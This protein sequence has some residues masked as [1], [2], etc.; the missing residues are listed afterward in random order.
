MIIQNENPL[1][2]VGGFSF[3]SK[4]LYF[5]YRFMWAKK[6]HIIL[7]IGIILIAS[8]LRFYRITYHDSY[9]D[10]ALLAFRDI[11][12]ID[13]DTSDVQTTP[14]QWFPEVPWWGHLSF[15]DHPI[16]FF[17]LQHW[18]LKVF[19]INL[20][21]VR[22]PAV[23]A[24][25]ASVLLMWLIGKKLF[26]ERVGYVA[27][28]LLAV[29]SYH[30]W[31]SRL[32]IQD[33]VMIVLI[34]LSTWILL[35]ARDEPRW[36]VVFGA[37]FGLGIIT[38]YTYLIMGPIALIYLLIER[39]PA[40]RHKQF[41]WGILAAVVVSSPTWLYNL[42]LYTATG[43]FDF[44]ISA[45]LGQQV[46]EW[47]YRLGRIQ[48]GGPVDRFV[49]FFRAMRYANSPW[50]NAIAVVSFAIAMGAWVKNK[51][52]QL[53]FII[54]STA[55]MWLWFFVI[56][57]TYRFVVM[58]IPF[59]ALLIGWFC[60]AYLTK[61]HGSTRWIYAG[62][63]L[64]I[65]AES[66]FSFN[67]F[68]VSRSWGRENVAYAKINDETQNFGFNQLEAY[69]NG[70]LKGKMSKFFGQPDYQFLTELVQNHISQATR[71]GAEPYPL[72]MMYD[73]DFNFMANLW[74]FSRRLIYEGWPV[75][76]DELFMQNAKDQ[77]DAYYR[78]Q[79]VE[80]F[81]YVT[82][83]AESVLTVPSGRSYTGV[84]LRNYLE[85]KGV[86]P[87]LI[88]NQRGDAAFWVYEF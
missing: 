86:K 22:L 43:H 60:D 85:K 62:G 33:G 5:S 58:I 1:T 68:L 49:N 19:G 30:V 50:F 69:L 11:G 26:N 31:V 87:V 16:F 4:M 77:Y 59:I 6:H 21:A 47:T 81:I 13:Y 73:Q 41:W 18:T 78:A 38:K 27:A 7:L 75:M 37:L 53:I 8:F 88:Q 34:L 24:G 25:I 36:W 57:S 84:A 15:H 82:S 42:F 35:K 76:S 51:N 48:V 29:Q 80:H 32:G 70:R 71:R 23:L 67:S 83:A 65:I 45:F 56:G 54:G 61:F 14:W 66:F 12:L 72:I 63:A 52:R 64:F 17:L 40:H 3:L 28:G 55:L 10:E 9:T 46:P 74:T 2:K 39:Y 44:Q 79:G 20:F